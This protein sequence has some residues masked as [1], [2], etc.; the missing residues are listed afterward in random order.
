[1]PDRAAPK[2][3]WFH[4]TPD[5]FVV[6]LLV[7]V[8]FLWLSERFRW[9]AFNHHKGWTVLIAATAVAVATALMAIW[10]LATLLIR[11]RTRFRIRTALALTVACSIVLGWLMAA[12]RQARRQAEVVEWIEEVVPR[13]ATGP[14]D[15]ADWPQAVTDWSA[16]PVG[17]SPSILATEPDWLRELMGT[18]FFEDVVEVSLLGE[19]ASDDGIARLAVL[20]HLRKLSIWGTVVTDRSMACLRGLSYLDDLELYGCHVTKAGFDAIRTMTRLRSLG[21]AETGLTDA[22]LPV[23]ANLRLL[24]N[25]YIGDTQVTDA[26][27]EQISQL[28][29]LTRLELMG[30]QITDSGLRPLSNLR[31]LVYLDVRLTG[32]SAEGVAKLQQALPGCRIDLLSRD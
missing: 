2:P 11:W 22:D 27:M 23:L 17:Q 8:C 28:T 25:L 19:S 6:G 31:G 1:M 30:T 9:F 4:L 32:V 14:D 13:Y 7:A 18:G 3:R 20:T 16:Y 26:G 21:L 24:K 10:F 15:P 29:Q 5:H 12:V